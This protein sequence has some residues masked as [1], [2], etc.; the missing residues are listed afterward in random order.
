LSRTIATATPAIGSAGLIT[1]LLC[2][3][4]TGEV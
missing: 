1:C 2:A 3:G 4:K